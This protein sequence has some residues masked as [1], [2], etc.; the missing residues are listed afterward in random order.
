ML[1]STETLYLYAHKQHKFNLFHQ[2]KNIILIL[3]PPLERR[4]RNRVEM[5]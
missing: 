3:I 4:N 2:L 1:A 5:E